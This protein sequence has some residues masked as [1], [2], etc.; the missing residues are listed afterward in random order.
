MEK[1]TIQDL[2]YGRISPVD[3]NMV[4][5]EE[6]QKHSLNFLRAAERFSNKLP[7]ELKEEFKRLYEE[8]MMADEILHRDGFCKGFE[9]GLRLT[10]EAFLKKESPAG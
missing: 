9:L 5:Q 2:Y 10:A 4:E 3:L 6:Y 8:E 7:L 1:E